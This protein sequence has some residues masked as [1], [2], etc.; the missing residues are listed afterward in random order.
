MIE[1]RPNVCGLTSPFSGAPLAARDLP[2]VSL[3][4]GLRHAGR[5]SNVA[6]GT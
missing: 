3:T 4:P 2:A 6:G 1:F 5:F